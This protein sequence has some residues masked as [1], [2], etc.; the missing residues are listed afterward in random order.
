MPCVTAGNRAKENSRLFRK[1]FG[2]QDTDAGETP[3]SYSF[4]E[5]LVFKW[6][7]DCEGWTVALGNTGQ[8]AY[9]GTGG[10]NGV[11]PLDSSCEQVAQAIDSIDRWRADALKFLVDTFSTF[12]WA[13]DK[14]ISSDDFTF[15]GLEIFEH[16][17]DPNACTLVFETIHDE[18]HLFRVRLEMGKPVSL[19]KG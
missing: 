9:I 19:G 11:P 8:K 1:L 10:D 7:R 16:E 2:R 5:G 17:Q 14:S 4:R 13:K 18:E 12:E 6:D 15:C 3:D